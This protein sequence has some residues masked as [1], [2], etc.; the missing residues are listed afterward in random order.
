MRDLVCVVCVLVLSW[1]FSL[2]TLLFVAWL[3]TLMGRSMF[4]YSHIHAAVFLYGS[5]AVCILLLIHTLV[6]N[7][8]YRVSDGQ[9]TF[10]CV[11]LLWFQLTEV[12]HL[13]ETDRGR[14]RR[15]ER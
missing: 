3:V 6:K 14:S 5:A 11:S 10:S 1:I 9:N 12:T 4:W 13:M 15:A 2:V 8:C 7:R